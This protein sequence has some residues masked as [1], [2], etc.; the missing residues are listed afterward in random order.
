MKPPS[1]VF[2]VD[3]G[4]GVCL[5]TQYFH[6]K[7]L[8]FLIYVERGRRCISVSFHVGERDTSR[9]DLSS[10]IQIGKYLTVERDSLSKIKVELLEVEVGFKSQLYKSLQM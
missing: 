6:S 2:D 7:I 9:L 3:L 5:C 10:K 4:L 1:L 8:P